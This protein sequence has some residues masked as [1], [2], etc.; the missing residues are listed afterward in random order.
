MKKIISIFLMCVMFFL[1]SFSVSAEKL[2]DR[3][4]TRLEA[5]RFIGEYI[6]TDMPKS[7]QYIELK[8][9]DVKK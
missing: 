7:Y 1:T 6:V 5:F 2:Q 8:F 4:I 3:E 9:S